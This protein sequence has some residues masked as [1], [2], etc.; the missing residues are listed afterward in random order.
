MLKTA[1][2]LAISFL[3]FWLL[4]QDVNFSQF[5]T[6]APYYNPAFTSAFTGNYRVSAIHRN[7]WIGFQDQPLSSFCVLGDIKFDLGL[8][9][10]KSDYLG[11]SVYFITDRAQQFDW[12]NN[13]IAVLLAYHKILDKSNDQYLSAG[14]GLGII[15]RSVNY[16]NLYFED[17]FDGLNKYNGSTNELLPPNI[18]SNPNI[19]FGIQHQVKLKRNLRVQTGLA[20]HHLFKPDASFYKNFDNVDYNGSNSF[21][22]NLNVTG[23]INISYRLNN[24]T[25]F[26]PKLLVSSQG[27]HFLTNIGMNLRRS[28][29]TLNQ[30]AVHFGVNTRV[31]KNE[32]SLAPVD[33]GFL[34]GFEIKNFILGMH[35][36][37]GIRDAVKYGAPTHS[38]EISL[39]L[40]GNYDNE[41]FICPTF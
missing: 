39:S 30:T 16:D 26:Y 8:Q 37:I 4:S 29:Y 35:Y 7:Q 38:M 3:P 24:F 34:V 40:I 12:N 13:E 32:R 22:S 14:I 21:A 17:Q 6:I 23:I 33:L 9:D 1:H 20:L 25:D 36:D 10:F 31:V 11:A 5:N 18:F 2:L 15:Q 28:F 41:G 27:A 19:K